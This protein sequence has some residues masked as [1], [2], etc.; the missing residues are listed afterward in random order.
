VVQEGNLDNWSYIWG[1]AEFS[2]Q[3]AY[4]AMIGFSPAPKIFSILW[5]SSCQAKHKFFFW[6][7]LHDRLN[8]RNL[9][10]RKNFVLQSYQC[11]FQCCNEEETLV[12]LF[13][14][15]PFA[16]NCW[17]FICPRR[18]RSLSILEALEDVRFKMKLPF[19]MEVLILSAWGIWIVRNN[20][21]FKDQNAEFNTWK[22]IFLQELRLLVHR[23]KKKHV[24]SFKEWIQSLS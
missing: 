1:N 14:A 6:L 5:K 10:R 3:K 12:H 24:Y 18:D 21:I 17:D 13:W 23:M 16:K 11:V 9:L 4:Q 20:K 15:C 19:A 8:T 2:S 7:L 22:A